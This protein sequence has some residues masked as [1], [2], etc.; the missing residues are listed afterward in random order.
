MNL[1]VIHPNE[2][3]MEELK[4]SFEYDGHQV[5]TSGSFR[6]AEEIAKKYDI[7]C[8]LLSN[9]ISD[10]NVLDFRSVLEAC[11]VSVS[12]VLAT[13]ASTKEI[14]LYLEYGYEEVL[15]W[16][17]D[18]LELKA[19]IRSLSRRILPKIRDDENPFQIKMDEFEIDLIRRELSVSGESVPLTS[20]EF[21]VLLF[22]IREHGRVLS[23]KDIAYEL[24]GDDGSLNYRTV[25]VYIRRIRDKLAPYKLDGLI[26]TKWG[27]GYYYPVGIKAKKRVRRG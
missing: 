10:R 8:C 12:I 5:F 24:W 18:I 7:R 23:R 21:Q 11:H 22:L 13:E 25:D 14:I 27:E 15:S 26:E 1:L 16:P 17:V 9:R 4:A 3:D 2:A 19:R 20:K 6:Q